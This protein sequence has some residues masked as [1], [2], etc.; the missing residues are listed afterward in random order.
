MRPAVEIAE[1]IRTG[2]DSAVSTITAA[3]E[4]AEAAHRDLNAFT[5]IDVGGALARAEAIDRLVQSGTDPGPLA[6][7]PIALKDLIDDAGMPNT[8]GSAFPPRIAESSATVVRRL[9]AAGGIIIGRTGLHEFAFGFTSENP[10]F[11]PV[12]NPWDRATSTGGSSGGSAAAV[13]SGVVPIAVGT[14]TGGSVRVPAALCGVVGLKTTHG[15]IPLTGVYPL[16][17][18]LDTVGPIA[19]NVGD[20]ALSYAVMAGDNEKDPWS[21][22]MP[23]DQPQAST[24][25][26]LSIGVVEQWMAPPHS[27]DVADGLEAFTRRCAEV[28]IDVERIDAPELQPPREVARAIGPEILDVHADRFARDPDRYGPDVAER[29]EKATEATVD[30]LLVALRWASAAR[31]SVERLT[32]AGYAALVA[33]TVGAMSKTIGRDEITIDGESVFH[34]EALARFT[35]PIN[36]IGLPAVALP[37]ADTTTPGV[38]V[39]LI[40]SMWSEARLLGLALG[41]EREGVVATAEPPIFFGEDPT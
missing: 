33:P 38:S 7:V 29:I 40:G 32:R 22:P 1:R 12:R 5:L 18:S 10:W 20:L 21:V 30:D 6:G 26:G 41:L 27:R 3:L 2:R 25:E 28:G 13:A 15:R 9:G 8:L 4:R 23:V 16:V 34:R 35:S 19:R 37:V 31:A 11:G 39:Q 36:R 14:D 24:L 17:P